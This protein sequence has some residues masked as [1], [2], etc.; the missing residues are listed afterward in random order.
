MFLFFDGILFI[1]FPTMTCTMYESFL[2]E[3]GFGY[4]MKYEKGEF[5]N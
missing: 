3:G 1:S 4:W 5:E 2:M